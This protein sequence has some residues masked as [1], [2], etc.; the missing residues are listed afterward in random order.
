VGEGGGQGLLLT[1]R[2]SIFHQKTYFAK[3]ETRRNGQTFHRNFAYL[4]ETKDK[5]NSILKHFTKQKRNQ[6]FITNHYKTTS[7][8][9][10]ILIKQKHAKFR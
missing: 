1:N 5:Q 2:V 8:W 10:F 4:D 6:N 7:Q 9:N 3:Y